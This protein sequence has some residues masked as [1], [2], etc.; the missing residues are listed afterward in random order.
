VAI[1]AASVDTEALALGFKKVNGEFTEGE[2][3][4]ARYSLIFKQ[5]KTAQGDFARTSGMLANSQRIE[6]AELE[7]A[8]AALGKDLL[9]AQLAV[10]KAEIA[11]AEA[12]E[13]AIK[14]IETLAHAADDATKP[15]GGL[16]AIIDGITQAIAP[17]AA[18]ANKYKDSLQKQAD[19][20]AEAAEH[21]HRLV[22]ETVDAN[23]AAYG[24]AGTFDRYGE[25][26]G[27]L[28]TKTRTVTAA[29]VAADTAVIHLTDGFESAKQAASQLDG[30]L[31]D[32]NA[33]LY[34]SKILAGD[35]A[36][37]QQD[38]ID[39]THAQNDAVSTLTDLTKKGVEPTD[40]SSKAWKKWHAE[41]EEAKRQVAILTGQLD[42]N[43]EALFNLQYQEKQQEGPKALYD[44]LLKQQASLN[45]ADLK[46]Q[47]YMQTLRALAL[48]SSNMPPVNFVQNYVDRLPSGTGGT[49]VRRFAEGGI[50]KA[51]PGG[52]LALIG[53][54]GQDE[55][56][57]PIGKG[58]T[59]G[60]LV[61]SGGGG[62]TVVNIN[63]H[64]VSVLT[65]G[66][67][68]S[69]ART[70]TPAIATELRRR[71]LLS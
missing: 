56:V 34:G 65:P 55:A 66:A 30:A 16:G 38:V 37:A 49:T 64:G 40:H 46:A 62:G 61:G 3:V 4:Q 17:G 54:A 53:E 39:A 15:I 12:V 6:N 70:I 44:W 51:S 71:R 14:G 32:L 57:V 45:K 60:R 50:V 59:A 10:T 18:A 22:V 28:A 52:T 31:A 58:A 19:T 1:S 27:R 24:A 33:R 36:Q 63:V 68:E 5:T 35:L 48:L 9:P 41:V 42:Q 43:R 11:M 7:N 2:K 13:P 20:S 21:T 69:L 29:T 23:R 25:G 47:A 8:K 67:A 26:I